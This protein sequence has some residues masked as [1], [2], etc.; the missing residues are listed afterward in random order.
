MNPTTLDRIMNN[1]G[2][3]WELIISCCRLYL[4][5]SRIIG[6][7]NED[8]DRVNEYK[9]KGWDYYHISILMPIYNIYCESY[10]HEILDSQ[11]KL[12]PN[13]NLEPER[14]WHSWFIDKLKPV[15]LANELFV[16]KVL[17]SLK[18]VYSRDPSTE[19]VE[20][21]KEAL[22]TEIRKDYELLRTDR[23]IYIS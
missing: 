3:V 7:F 6:N 4:H 9:M 18:L 20:L 14:E 19:L 12:F 22:K 11:I 17:K 10:I 2:H 21:E 15:I 5:A 23:F 1:Q 13:E 16:Q 8:Y